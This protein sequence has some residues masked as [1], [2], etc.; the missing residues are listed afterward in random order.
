MPGKISVREF[1]YGGWSN[2]IQY[3]ADAG[4]PNLE[5]EMR[6]IEELRTIAASVREKGLEVL[7]L[8]G[9]VNLDSDESIANLEAMIDACGELGIGVFFV[10]ASGSELARPELMARLH[11][12]GERAHHRPMQAQRRGH[13][14]RAGPQRQASAT[15]AQ[16]PQRALHGAAPQLAASVNCTGRSAASSRSWCL[17]RCTPLSTCVF[18]RRAMKASTAG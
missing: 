2:A 1:V 9:H 16:Q 12:L 13:Q 3:I 17:M 7:T 4:I 5:I 11:A 15:P 14:H 8:S 18:S 10:S 6:P